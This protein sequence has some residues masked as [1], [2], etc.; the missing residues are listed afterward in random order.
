MFLLDRLPHLG[1][2]ALPF[3]VQ[4]PNQEDY[5]PCSGTGWIEGDL[6][7]HE[8]IF[9][10]SPTIFPAGCYVRLCQVSHLLGKIMQH[11]NN[12]VLDDDSR[13]HEVIQLNRSLQELSV[14]I[15]A[16]LNED[17]SM[18]LHSAIPLCYSGMMILNKPYSGIEPIGIM[19]S[20]VIPADF[21]NHAFD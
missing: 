3:S 16:A 5:L 11:L 20:L 21:R 9:F 12:H 1:N 8:P 14:V 13:F 18:A 7:I 15:S 19:A 6:G 4:D 17:Q 2:P 10:S